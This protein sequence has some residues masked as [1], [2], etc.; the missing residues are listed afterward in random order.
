MNKK[1]EVITTVSVIL[2]LIIIVPFYLHIKSGQAKK[3][4]EI[5]KCKFLNNQN[6]D[7]LGE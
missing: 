1:G 6:C 2:G 7:E 4:A 3:N 5:I